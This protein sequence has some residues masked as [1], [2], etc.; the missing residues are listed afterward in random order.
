MA[1]PIDFVRLGEL[2]VDGKT[3]LVRVDYN[4]PFRP[5]S[6]DI[7]DDSRIRAS[8][9]TLKYLRERSCKLVLCSHLGRPKG[10]AVDALRMKPVSQRLAELLGV[11][12]AQAADCIGDEVRSAVLALAPGEVMMLENLR[13][14]HEEERNDLDFAFNL[15]LLAEI[16]VNDAFGAAHRAHASTEGVTRFLPSAAGLLMERELQVLGDAMESPSRPFAAVLGGAKVSDKIVVLE[17]LLDRVDVLIIGGGMCATFIKAKGHS[18]GNSAVEDDRIAFA[19]TVIRSA[20]KRKVELLLPS[21][22]VIA[23]AFAEHA[24]TKTVGIANIPDGWRIMDIGADTAA[25]YAA[26]LRRCRTVIWNGPMGVF[27]W[28]AFAS[29]TIAVAQTLAALADATTVTGGGSTMEAVATLGLTER[30]THVSSG[31]GA[32]LEFMEGRALPGVVALRRKS[33]HAESHDD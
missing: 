1:K 24:R 27:E 25:R 14:H 32:S 28:D 23:D 29:G 21:D 18:V 15:S 12:V 19:Q 7:S 20:Q 4:V 2:D 22:V 33:Q 11:R 17:R 30:M 3:A 5:G 8:L 26:T 31:G 10:Q 16:F 13:F 9:P 6:A